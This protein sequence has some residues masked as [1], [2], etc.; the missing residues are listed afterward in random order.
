MGPLRNTV[1][2]G[3]EN[4]PKKMILTMNDCFF[5]FCGV[6]PRVNDKLFRTEQET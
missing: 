2:N 4:K 3:L 6:L 1:L 5:S